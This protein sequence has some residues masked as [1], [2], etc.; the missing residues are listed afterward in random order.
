MQLDIRIPIGLLFSILGVVL[1]VF[2]KYM[3][4]ARPEIYLRSLGINVN[5]GW[6]LVLVA[7]GL[8]MLALAWKSR[9]SKP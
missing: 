5:Y 2:G 7:F 8:A 3:E 6:G 1:A 9:K 4:A